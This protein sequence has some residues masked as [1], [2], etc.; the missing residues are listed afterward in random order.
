MLREAGFRASSRSAWRHTDDR[1]DVVRFQ[2]FSAYDAAV[3]G[4]TTFSFAVNLGTFLRYVPPQRS[5]RK[6]KNGEP[7]PAEYECQFRGRLQPSIMQLPQ[8]QD[9]WSIDSE[10]KNLAWCIH[11]VA[12]QIPK[13][14]SWFAALESRNEVLRILLQQDEETSILWGFGRRPSPMRSYLTGYLALALKDDA[15]AIQHLGDAVASGCFVDLFSSVE[16]ARY[17]AV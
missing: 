12:N 3:L 7:F 15:L 2:S 9:V 10:G 1:V 4:V 5:P 17:R 8:V 16:G 11:D 6:I 14:L 13:A